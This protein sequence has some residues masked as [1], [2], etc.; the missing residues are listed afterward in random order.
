MRLT[1][2]A[3]LS[4]VDTGSRQ[5]RRCGLSR[6]RKVWLASAALLLLLG[7]L[8]AGLAL[9]LRAT[10]AE[11]ISQS[12]Q[13]RSAMLSGAEILKHSGFGLALGQAEAADADF[14]VSEKDFARAHTLLTE[15]VLIRLLSGLPFAD[16]QIK[17]ARELTDIGIHVSRMGQLLVSAVEAPLAE[18]TQQAATGQDP[19]QKL[20]ELLQALD[21]K[22]DQVRQELHQVV[23]D[24][25]RIPSTGL[26]PELSRAAA[27]FDSKVDL[28]S[29][30]TSLA[31]LERDQSGL[32]ALLGATGARTY[33]VLQQDPAELRGT[34]GFIGTVGFLSFDRG[35]MA[36]F[37]PQAIERIDKRPDN[38]DVLGRPGTATH[39][40]PPYPLEHVFRLQSWELRDA[41]WSPDFP[42]ASREAEFLLDREVG[43]RVDGVIAIDPYFIE[44]LL[45]IIGP[46]KIP[47]TGDVVDQDNFYAVTLSR[48]EI[49][50]PTRKNFLSYAAKQILTRVLKLPPNKYYALLQ[51]IQVSCDT[52]SV[53]AYFHD[54]KAE[55]LADHHQCGGEVQS[56]P[57]DGLMVVES[58]V[59]GN[60]DDFWMKRRF[61]LGISV[62]SDGTAR[63]TLR[64]HYDSLTPHGFILTGRWG[65]TG[66]L[67][68]YL[69][70]ST[71]IV[72]ASGASLDQTTELGR[73]LLQG[74]FYVEFYKSADITV[75]YDEDSTVMSARQGRLGLFWQKQAGRVADPVSVDVKLPAG[76]TMISARMGSSKIP[77]G[78]ISTDLTTDREF[79]FEYQKG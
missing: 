33:L 3:D 58:N 56:P 49:V 13:G 21:P 40:E 12:N 29:V 54:E 41:N 6:R 1:N 74:W 60:K 76:W 20:L 73:H 50:S 32:R 35:K 63:H 47:E 39:V 53:Q 11:V 48:V 19:G 52:R 8:A 68:I 79:V 78:P 24:R 38:S 64:L 16:R 31:E 44:R 61:S 72:S 62:N 27:E 10:V 59:G 75:V 71:A 66:W 28:P 57:G 5:R 17:A 70:P 26:L 36:P 55:A 45:A 51:A 30:E 65:Y 18:Q 34:G 23:A 37:D 42:T 7:A 25:E 67:R 4:V 43:K 77:D 9:I 15:P 14:R 22:L 46:I 2:A 69:P